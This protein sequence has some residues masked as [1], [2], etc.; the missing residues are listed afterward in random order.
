MLSNRSII[1]LS[2]SWVVAFPTFASASCSPNGGDE[3]MWLLDVGAESQLLKVPESW[4]VSY[5]EGGHLKVD[6]PLS[7]NGRLT[8]LG[9]ELSAGY[10]RTDVSKPFNGTRP[11]IG[12]IQD[13]YLG[14]GQPDRIQDNS[15]WFTDQ[16]SS[17]DTYDDLQ[18]MFGNAWY[19]MYADVGFFTPLRDYR[20]EGVLCNVRRT[21]QR[22]EPD[23]CRL[24]IELGEIIAYGP[25]DDAEGRKVTDAKGGAGFNDILEWHNN[26]SKVLAD[27]VVAGDARGRLLGRRVLEPH[28]DGLVTRSLNGA[29]VSMPQEYLA[30]YS[31]SNDDGVLRRHM[32]T[33]F[34]Y[35]TVDG[36]IKPGKGMKWDDKSGPNWLLVEAHLSGPSAATLSEEAFE[37]KDFECETFRRDQKAPDYIARCHGKMKLENGLSVSLT[38]NT[39]FLMANG[40]PLTENVVEASALDE[41]KLA[42]DARKFLSDLIT[43]EL[44]ESE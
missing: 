30:R 21:G 23:S 25:T 17:N 22:T 6:V 34:E 29:L 19:G 41:K 9:V 3:K 8:C 20:S 11:S 18:D 12:N 39:V 35:S 43:V 27:L 7:V 13:W 36:T 4:I 15:I 14:K 40:V 32:A 38:V 28:P 37:E 2:F 33:L 24:A 44:V 16:K 42:V 10:R 31:I 26:L 5:R 1:A